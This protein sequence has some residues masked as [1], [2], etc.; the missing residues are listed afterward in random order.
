[1]LNQRPLQAHLALDKTALHAIAAR[2]WGKNS[3]VC[4]LPRP[5]R[6]SRSGSRVRSRRQPAAALRGG[7]LRRWGGRPRPRR[8]SRSGSRVRSRRQPAA[9]LRISIISE[10]GLALVSAENVA[11]RLQIFETMDRVRFQVAAFGPLVPGVNG[12]N[13]RLRG[14]RIQEL[15]RHPQRLPKCR[16]R[17]A[18]QRRRERIA[19]VQ[20]AVGLAGARARI[21]PH[22][23]VRVIG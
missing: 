14:I 23:H 2:G 22:R 8:T 16:W 1:M 18:A 21:P 5:R 4:C 6:T 20:I 11:N 17:I 3:I 13:A 15:P 19:L 12:Q 7:P 10:N 9:A